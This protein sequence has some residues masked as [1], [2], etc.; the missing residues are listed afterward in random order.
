M[1][2]KS[3][4]V[5]RAEQVLLDMINKAAEIGSAAVDEIPLVVQELLT[6][7]LAESLAYTTLSLLILSGLMF[8]YF[9]VYNYYKDKEISD[10]PECL[11]VLFSVFAW[12]PVFECFNLDW[13]KILIAPRV[14]LLEYAASLIK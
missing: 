9:K 7:K 4:L 3:E 13:L 6:W 1:S 12:I 11:F 14:Y 10:H 8:F 5:Q 2:E